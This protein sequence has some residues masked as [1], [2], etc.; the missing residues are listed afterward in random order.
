MQPRGDGGFDLRWF[1]P[2]VEVD[3]C[4]HATLASAHVL[5]ETRPARH[6]RRPRSSTPAAASS[7]PR[8][9]PTARCSSTSP[10]RRPS[11]ATPPGRPP[12]RARR[13]QGRVARARP[14]S[15][16]CSSCPTPRSCASSRP[17]SARS[18]ALTDVRGVYV[19]AAGD[20]GTLRHRVALLRTP[21]R[22]RRRPGHRIDALRARA[23]YWCERLGKQRAARAPGLAR[24]AATMRVRLEATARCSIG[25]RGHRAARASSS[26]RRPS[27]GARRS[28]R[29]CRRASETFGSQPSS[30]RARS[31]APPLRNGVARLLRLRLDRDRRA[32][33]LADERDQVVERDLGA[34]REV[35]VGAGRDVALGRREVA[36][37]RCR[38]RT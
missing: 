24:A 14:A 30:S 32:R 13:R 19:T 5:F 25:Q 36:R 31:I 15:S 26:T 18:A 21:C 1:T 6:R 38:R 20:D 27:S 10:P 7:G 28:A 34:A 17:T 9:S 37:P 23:P 3:L 8:A 16:S 29:R 35:H 4:G 12:R 2:E 22:D 11:R 33:E